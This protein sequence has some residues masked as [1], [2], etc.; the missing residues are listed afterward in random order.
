MAMRTRCS[1]GA[2]HCSSI[3]RIISQ[4]GEEV[5]TS[6]SN[7]ASVHC[8]ALATC[9]S[10]S[11]EALPRPYSMFAKCRS[12][13]CAAVARALRVMPRRARSAP[14]RW[15]RPIKYGFLSSVVAA[16]SDEFSV[17]VCNIVLDMVE[18]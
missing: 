18:K 12:D 10:T 4:S 11:T 14:T 2:S 17:S 6:P 15:P 7:S 3:S 5:L 8:K 9:K 16:L 1:V 13:T